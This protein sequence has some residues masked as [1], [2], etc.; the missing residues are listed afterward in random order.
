MKKYFKKPLYFH[1]QTEQKGLKWNLVPKGG[2][3]RAGK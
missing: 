1:L 3:R 2:E